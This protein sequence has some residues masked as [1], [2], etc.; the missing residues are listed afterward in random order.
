MCYDGRDFDL[1]E[2]ETIVQLSGAFIVLW[3]AATGKKDY[4]Q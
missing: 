3:N 4:I 2:D 1:V